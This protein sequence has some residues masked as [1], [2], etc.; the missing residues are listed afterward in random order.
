MAT[1]L[2][3]DDHE[4][5]R[6]LLSTLLGYQDHQ[7]VEASDGV[8][9]LERAR[10]TRPDLI[11]TDILMPTMDGYEF[12]RRVR[13][14]A[15]LAAIPVI[16]YSANYLMEETRAL[17]ERC[18]VEYIVP[19]PVDPKELLRTVDKALGLQT[20]LPPM[21]AVEDFDREHIRVLT[22]K[23]STQAQEVQN[24]N[25]RLEALIEVGHEL[26]VAQDPSELVERYC[27]T[28]REMIGSLCASACVTDDIGRGLRHFCSG[29]VRVADPESP[30]PTCELGGPVVDVLWRVPARDYLA[31]RLGGAGVSGGNATAGFLSGGAHPDANPNVRLAGAGKQA[32]RPRIYNPR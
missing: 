25:A 9:G 24:L 13:E 31:G 11:I 16:F 27:R 8:E 22:D 3:V 6:K 20:A 12:T 23:L 30:C 19:K 21:E 14:D 5:N 17:A 15:A 28:A 1:I 26:N 10:A 32:R 4:T 18:G 7:T 2:I 29:R